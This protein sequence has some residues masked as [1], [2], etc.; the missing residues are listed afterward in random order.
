MKGFKMNTHTKNY[1][2]ILLFLMSCLSYSQVPS[3]TMTRGKMWVKARPNGALDRE[4]TLGTNIFELAYPGYYDCNTEGSGGWDKNAIYIAGQIKG[5]DV[6]WIIRNGTYSDND[7]LPDSSSSGTYTPKFSKN[8]NLAGAGPEELITGRMYSPKLDASGNRHLGIQIDGNVMVWSQPKYA[9]FVL[10]YCKLKNIDDDTIKNFYYTRWVSPNGPWAPSSVS[11]GWD[12]EYLWENDSLG[13]VFYDDDTKSPTSTWPK[14]NIYP[15][16]ITGNAGDP[17]NIGTQGSRNYKL[18][19]PALYAYTFIPGSNNKLGNKKVWRKIVSSST[20]AP[21][22]ELMPGF[23]SEMKNYS[24]LVD[25][26]TTNEQPKMS[27]R[28]ADSINKA[29][30]LDPDTVGAGSLWERNPRYLYAIGPYDIPPGGTIDWHEVL[31]CGQMDRNVTIR[32]IMGDS[33]VTTKFVQLGM[34]N[35]RDNWHAAQYLIRNKYKLGSNECPPPTPCDAPKVGNTNELIVTAGS[36][37]DTTALFTVNGKTP[38]TSGAR[39][40]GVFITW[41]AVHRVNSTT[42]YRDPLNGK[43]DFAKYRIYRS[44]ISVEG[45]WVLIDSVM[46]DTV[47]AFKPYSAV[48]PFPDYLRK[49]IA[50]DSVINGLSTSSTGT[51]TYFVKATPLLPYRYCVTSVDT[52]GNESAKTGYNYYSVSSEPDASNNQSKIVVA[53][54]PFRQ[55]SGYNDQSENKRLVFINI[56]AK[57]TIRIYTVALDLVRTIEHNSDS[58]LQSWGTSNG[59]DYML[60]DF[61]QN[62]APGMYIYQCE[63]H[64]SGHEGETSVGKFAIIR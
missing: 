61:A 19:S 63:S 52:S 50:V 15:G 30:N 34:A 13:F 11:T 45:P 56:P 62:V 46:T 26:M 7:I 42:Y 35:L 58:G 53:P 5:Q 10:I 40:P 25:F 39:V 57:C 3:F 31:I 27:W 55:V 44:D 43:Y 18:Y 12:K 24:T 36:I 48:T 14:Y 38:S 64:V 2:L 23:N 17:G 54:N 6:D 51:I 8:Y 33:L 37:H 59:Q 16:T 60:T 9:D 4:T 49:H 1:L 47:S 29:Q 28:I 22:R 32:G 20:S 41:P 21:S